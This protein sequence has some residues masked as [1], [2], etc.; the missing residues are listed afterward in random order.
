MV[1][2]AAYFWIRHCATNLGLR[3]K[4]QPSLFASS[5]SPP[6][7]LGG[8]PTRRHLGPAAQIVFILLR[9]ELAGAIQEVQWFAAMWS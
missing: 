5:A 3:K 1:N 7:G 6:I 4:L 8:S 9:S 2:E